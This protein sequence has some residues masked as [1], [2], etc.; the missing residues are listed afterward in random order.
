MRA[1]QPW[2]SRLDILWRPAPLDLFSLFS[3]LSTKECFHSRGQHLCKFIGTKESV[4]IRKEFNS[5]R[6]GLGHQYGRRFKYGCRDVIWKHSI[7]RAELES[8]INVFDTFQMTGVIAFRQREVL[9]KLRSY[10]WEMIIEST[11]L[12]S[13]RF[14]K[15]NIIKFY[16]SS[17]WSGIWRGEVDRYYH[18]YQHHRCRLYEYI[19]VYFFWKYSSRQGMVEE[20]CSAFSFPTNMQIM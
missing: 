3:S 16:L 19:F 1:A 14:S 5:H 2:I 12:T 9:R 18:Y 11:H 17:R 4:C 6:T 8:V 13:H 20:L 15:R 10:G 7:S